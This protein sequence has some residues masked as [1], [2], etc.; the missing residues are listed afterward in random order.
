MNGFVY[1]QQ[2]LD[3]VSAD[4]NRF[5]QQLDVTS[6]DKQNLDKVRS[7]L[8]KQIEDLT[9]EVEKLKLANSTLQKTRDQ[10]EDEKEDSGLSLNRSFLIVFCHLLIHLFIP[11]LNQ[12]ISDRLG[13]N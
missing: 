13:S 3:E 10:L 1:S 5:K 8:A 9:S 7:S 4:R 6:N 12:S 11:S 2:Q